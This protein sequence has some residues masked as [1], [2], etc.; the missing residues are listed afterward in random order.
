[1]H[2]L[3]AVISRFGNGSRGIV[4]L[5]KPLVVDLDGTLIHTDMLHESAL[6]VFRDSPFETLRIPFL[7]LKGKAFLKRHLASK[8]EFDPQA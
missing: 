5:E 7:L 4:L 8:T 3:C 1:M 2:G 6:R